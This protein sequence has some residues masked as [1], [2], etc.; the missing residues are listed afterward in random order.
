M[1]E[2]PHLVL[3]LLVAFVQVLKVH[4]KIA[5]VGELIGRLCVSYQT[6]LKRGVGMNG[7]QWRTVGWHG[8]APG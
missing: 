3:Q 1:L 6:G 4:L 5:R 2:V 8:C 7:M